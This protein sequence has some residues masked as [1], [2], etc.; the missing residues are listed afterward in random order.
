MADRDQIL[1]MIDDIYTARAAGDRDTLAKCWASDAS[2]RIAG[3]MD[4]A[5]GG[6]VPHGKGNANENV[7]ALID[8][9]Q[10]HDLKRLHAVVEGDTAA[11]HWHLRVS[12]G[13]GEPV[14]TEIYD[15]WKV[16]PDGKIC[17]LV[18]FVDTA[19]MKHL[20]DGEAQKLEMTIPA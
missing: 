2:L 15:L 1:Q 17:S 18:Q 10:F 14:D 7:S 8:L 13:G 16:G 5:S 19:L 9:F 20:L 4:L 3:R 6:R 11:V 12:S